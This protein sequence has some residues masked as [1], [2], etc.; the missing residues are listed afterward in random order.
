MSITNYCMIHFTQWTFSVCV[1]CNSNY[2]VGDK[3]NEPDECSMCPCANLVQNLETRSPKEFGKIK[4][5][6]FSILPVKY[7]K[8]SLGSFRHVLYLA[9]PVKGKFTST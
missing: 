9:F 7:L 8:P 5:Y 3:F 4:I 6:T 2:T 1:Y